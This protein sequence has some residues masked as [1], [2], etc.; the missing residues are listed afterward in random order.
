M[1]RFPDLDTLQLALTTGAVP[2]AVSQTAAVAGFD[3]RGPIW[4]KPS[5]R[6]PGA[7]QAELR[8]LGVESVAAADVPVDQHVG[9][10]PQMLPLRRDPAAQPPADKT[11]VLFDL[12]E[13]QLPELVGEILR[14]G[15]DRQGFRWLDGGDGPR[16]LLRVIGP[17][18]YSLLRALD[19]DGDDR[20]PCAFVE[21]SPR[22]LVEVGYTHPLVDRI[23]PPAGKMILL[24]APRRWTV[25]DE[26]TFRDI[27]EVLEFP[28][29]KAAA[30]WRP[31]ELDRRISVPL[32]LARGGV[33][34]AAELWVLRDRGEEQLDALV[35]NADDRLL[36]RLAFAVG[37]LDGATVVVLRA[38]PSKQP[39]PV[40]VLEGV[41]FRSYLKLPN[42]F[43]PC[44]TR[45]HP[46]LRRDAVARLLAS[47]PEQ[48]TWLHPLG[49]GRFAPEAL[50]DAAFRPLEDWVE[51]VLDRDHK[52]L[53]A[54]FQAARFDFEPFIC[55]DDRPEPT[56]KPPREPSR[57]KRPKGDGGHPLYDEEIDED[58]LAK[59]QKPATKPKPPAPESPA[60]ARPDQL[61]RRLGEV[62]ARFL[63]LKTPL[64]DPDRRDLWREMA[65]LNAALRRA[66]DATVCWSHAVWELDA[67]PEDWLRAWWQSE[68]KP[69]GRGTM[70]VDDLDRVLDGDNPALA[71]LRA[72]ATYLLWSAHAEA[73]PPELT[74]RLGR[75]QHFLEVHESLLPTRLCWLAWVALVKLS[76]GDVLA[77]ARARDRMLE[78]LYHHGLNPHS[79]LPGFLRFSGSVGGARHRAVRDQL[80]RL[81]RAARR[82]VGEG[83]MVAPCTGEFADL[84]FAYGLARLGD[85]ASCAR[86]LEASLAT[87]KGRDP[88]STWLAL[89]YEFRIRQALEGKPNAGQLPEEMLE[90]LKPRGEDKENE[91]KLIRYKIDR[92][93]QHSRI[94]EPHEEIN[95][96]R[97]WHGRFNDELGRELAE[98]VD[99]NDRAELAT[100]L[101]RLLRSKRT[102]H[103][104]DLQEARILDSALELSPRLGEAFA[105]EVLDRVVP[106][107]AKLDELR[108]QAV[109]LEKGLRLAAHFDQA[110]HVQALVARFHQL[111]A[112]QRGAEATQA[113]EPLLGQC[114]RGLRKL[115]M[116]DEIN[117]LLERLAELVLRGQGLQA[118]GPLGAG[119]EKRGPQAGQWART[120]RLL[121]HVASGWSYFGQDDRAWPI[122]DEARDLLLQG[123]LPP[124]DQSPLA[125]GYIRALGQAPVE[126][127][128][129]RL[130][131]LFRGL[132][133]VHDTFTTNS[134]YSL[135]RLD[136]IEAAVLSLISDD[137]TLDP[138]GRRW[139]DDDE[140]LV[141]RR[142]HR[143]VRQALAG[144]D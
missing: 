75:V 45:L 16:A 67:P 96:Y 36:G 4:V 89:A 11:P 39:P 85:A 102:G 74:G 112:A 109:L 87:L 125:C 98:L 21:R 58:A 90:S 49:D 144:A 88:V 42:L 2:A 118:G 43:L 99:L 92:L 23:Q 130:E 79:D 35:R 33:A 20:S 47:D 48:V 113:L 37:Q 62:E 104:V 78:R 18:Y 59:P 60:R 103:R 13:A 69:D 82:W 110:E 34:E 117:R 86:L 14:L 124:L 105:R 30:D 134:H 80:L 97:H 9:C 131:E 142:I 127:A 44:G 106:A 129:P 72:L 12:P 27:Y 114:F 38:R 19:R 93:R 108:E 128:L 119:A 84:M 101:N 107:V 25:L 22:V 53:E 91:L 66:N 76:R 15:N 63:A 17:P 1:L 31:A 137:L 73:T 116:R 7:S 50:P 5:R 100:R 138:A 26:G 40:L 28:L 10:W 136:V 71:D 52:A 143:D 24:R 122:L 95:P 140:F 133:R 83:R 41:G 94:L 81:Q 8:R 46:P 70:A 139:L 55:A 32:R 120:L 57:P 77:L 111:L 115:G 126:R 54:W 29:P 141:R 56:K 3:A 123:D 6:L 64:D 65:A 132:E 68:A 121:L 61:Q 51:Y 135:S